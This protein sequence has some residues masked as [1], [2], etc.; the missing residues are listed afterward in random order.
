MGGDRSEDDDE[1]KAMMG[2]IA[3][4]EDTNN[5]PKDLRL[6]DDKKREKEWVQYKKDATSCK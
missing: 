3:A 1:F 6:V 4:G 2:W 5:L